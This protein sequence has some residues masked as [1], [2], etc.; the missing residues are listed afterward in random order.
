MFP[1]RKK[2]KNG[3]K[4]ERGRGARCCWWKKSELKARKE[5]TSGYGGGREKKRTANKVES[6]GNRGR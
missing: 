3:E 5:R 6:S 2:N 4:K 1:L